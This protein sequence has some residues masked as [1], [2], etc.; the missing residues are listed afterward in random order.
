MCNGLYLDFISINV[1]TEFDTN[2]SINSQT[3]VGRPHGRV[4]KNINLLHS[5]SLEL[6]TAVVSSLDRATCET[7]QVMLV[8]GQVVFSGTSRFRPTYRRLGSK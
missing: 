1:C 4:V 2:P 7:S 5:K 8:D 3:I 6:L